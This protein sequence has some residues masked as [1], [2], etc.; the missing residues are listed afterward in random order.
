[1]AARTVP[2]QSDLRKLPPK[3]TMSRGPFALQKD[4][5]EMSSHTALEQRDS[6]LPRMFETTGGFWNLP[7]V[8]GVR[9]GASESYHLSRDNDFR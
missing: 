5:P 8:P 7:D 4:I 6:R 2:D 1:M 3:G 9:K